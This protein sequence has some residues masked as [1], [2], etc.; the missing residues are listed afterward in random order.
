[1]VHNKFDRNRQLREYDTVG[2]NPTY[3]FLYKNNTVLLPQN[4]A[5]IGDN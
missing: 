3:G 5:D 2:G 4:T 1:M